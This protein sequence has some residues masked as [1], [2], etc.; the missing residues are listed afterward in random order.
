MKIRT[1]F[2]SNSSSSSF[3]IIGDIFDDDAV[4]DAYAK[5]FPK[6]DAS[7]E[8]NEDFDEDDTYDMIEKL[9][10]G[11]KLSY[12]RGVD[13]YYESWAVGMHW[14][15]MKNDETKKDFVA[16]V[17][18]ELTNAFPGQKIEVKERVDGGYE[19]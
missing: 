5:K 2:V 17:K 4:R 18:D 7:S 10:A 9:I 13:N 1:D 6:T 3:M 8:E 15:D 12:E 19:G 16:R 11:T 14:D